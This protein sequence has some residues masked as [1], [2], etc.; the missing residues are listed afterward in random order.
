MKVLHIT[1]VYEPA[2][3]AGGVVR[4]LSQL[5]RQLGRLGL[6]VTV[7]TTDSAGNDSL[8]VP[9]NQPLDVGGVRV[10]YFHTP[11]PLQFRYSRALGRACRDMVG[12]F[13]IM[14]LTSFWNYPGI[15]AGMQARRQ[16]IPYVISTSGTLMPA[17]RRRSRS[18]LG[19]LK[20]WLYMQVIEKRNLRGAA[21]IRYASHMER[22]KTDAS[23]PR[24]PSFVVPT[25]LDLGEFDELPSRSEA[26]ARLRLPRDVMVVSFLGRLNPAKGLEA[27]VRAFARVCRETTP[28]R[29]L[30]AGPDDG[31]EAEIRSLV[32][33]ANL[34]RHVRFMGFVDPEERS[35]LL[36]ATD[37]FALTSW[38]ESFGCSAVEAMAAGVPVLVSENVGICREVEMDGAGL[39][40]PVQVDAIAEALE[41][42]LLRPDLL[43]HMG[44]RAHVS[45]RQRYDIRQ[46]GRTM[47]KAYEDVLVGRHSP[48]CQWVS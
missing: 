47:A 22:A 37:L 1:P 7:F 46:V 21:A 16:G 13:D 35:Y 28:A 40:V 9:T 3:E 43:E 17:A 23:L 19:S 14:Q 20:K 45:A 5:C 36:S 12:D 24:I 4:A 18:R 8:R 48:E 31:S 38:F 10:F 11:W 2:W 29:L 32:G 41:N 44:R 27:L 34:E 15:P 42:L 26:R 33:Q 30:I 39:V 6:D 25:G